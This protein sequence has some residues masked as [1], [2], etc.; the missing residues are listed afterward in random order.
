[1][2]SCHHVGFSVAA[3]L[4]DFAKVFDV[5]SHHLLLGKLRLLG[6]CN[7]LIDRIADFLIVCVMRVSVSS[8]CSSLMD[9]RS[10]VPQGSVL[11]R[12][13]FLLFVNHLP[14]SVISKCKFFCG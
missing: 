1:M 14:T 5:V 12:L 11:D 4:F 7:P 8:I 6:F 9:V 2:V 10:G 13:L 3:V